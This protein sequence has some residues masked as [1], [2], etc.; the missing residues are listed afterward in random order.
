MRLLLDSG[1]QA[2]KQVP[3]ESKIKISPLHGAAWECSVRVA[4]LLIDHGADVNTRYDRIGTP[5]VLAAYQG[6]Y[7][8]VEFLLNKGADVLATGDLFVNALVAAA[9]GRHRR[10]LRLLLSHGARFCK[11]DWEGL[12]EW[13]GEGYLLKLDS[14]YEQVNGKDMQETIEVLLAAKGLISN[15]AELISRSIEIMAIIFAM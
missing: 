8:M 5:L 12:K 13:Y 6:R 10:I 14:I 2:S 15:K 7:S 4:Q 11:S 9:Q 1:A 3:H